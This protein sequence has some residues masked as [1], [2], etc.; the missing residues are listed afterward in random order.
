MVNS[1]RVGT[2]G[3]SYEDWNG[4]VYPRPA[5]RA[6]ST[7]S[8]LMAALFD[9]NEIN[10]TFYRIPDARQTADWARR[11]GGKSPL[12]FHREALPRLHARARGRR[13]PTRRR[14]SRPWSRS[15]TR[16]G[17][18]PC[19]SSSRSPSTTR[20]REPAGARRTSWSG[21]RS[22]PLAVEFRH[23]SWDREETRG[24]LAGA[25]GA[26][27]VNI[28]QPRLHGNLAGHE[29]RDRAARLLPLPRTQRR[30][31]VRTRH[32]ERGALQLSLLG[33][34]ARALGRA[35]PRGGDAGVAQ[36]RRRTRS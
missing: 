29:P 23:A 15:P 26:A 8:R 32:L 17:S 11:V 22:L 1:I 27:F 19:S 9:T 35:D 33:R 16:T 25:H 2:A 7:G 18:A 10:S 34:G 28:D 31:V 20:R 5:A 36:G 13:R 30:E 21:S 14:S 24:L 12:P 4:I 3:W 6:A